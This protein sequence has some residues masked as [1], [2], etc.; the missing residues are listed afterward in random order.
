MGP[1]Q[2]VFLQIISTP[3]N[4]PIK[5]FLHMKWGGPPYHTNICSSYG[6]TTFSTIFFHPMIL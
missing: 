1:F 5:Y 6:S 4:L 3:P 2:Q